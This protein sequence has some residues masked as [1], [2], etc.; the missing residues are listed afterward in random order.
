MND[1]EEEINLDMPHDQNGV[2][3]IPRFW[4]RVPYE[5]RKEFLEMMREEVRNPPQLL[6]YILTKYMRM[7]RAE[8]AAAEA[9]NLQPEGERRK[10]AYFGPKPL[11]STVA[12]NVEHS[13]GE[14]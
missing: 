10:L 5:F 14:Q 2:P 12:P 13:S 6:T 4:F 1:S 8:K 11:K 3:D 7:L 9:T